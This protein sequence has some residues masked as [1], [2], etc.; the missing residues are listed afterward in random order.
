MEFEHRVSVAR[1]RVGEEEDEARLVVTS[2]SDM[3]EQLPPRSYV[4]AEQPKAATHA[5]E[6]RTI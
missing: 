1:G 2:T 4:K 5:N 3:G 6:Y